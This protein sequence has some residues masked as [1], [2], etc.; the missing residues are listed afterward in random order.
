MQPAK[1]DYDYDIDQCSVS[2]KARLSAFREKR[3][4]WM[5]WLERDVHHNI[6]DQIHSIM[7]NDA[8]YRSLN[9][10]RRFA[11]AKNP[12]ASVNGML[13]EF[14]DRGYISTQVLDICKVTDKS[15]DDPKK[16]VIS[17]RR[18]LDD[19]SD[20]R[21][22]LTRENFVSYDGLPYDYAAAHQAHMDS[23]TAEELGKARWIST[24]GPDAWGT[25]ELMHSAFDKLSGIAE[26]ERTRED[27]VHEDVFKTVE[28]W[29]DA[30]I[31][32]KLRIHRNKFIGHAADE[33]SRRIEPLDR[34]GLSLDEIA[35]TQR[36]VIRIATAIGSH[37]L[38]DTA[39]GGVVPTPQFNV[40]K[41]LDMP[42][43]PAVNMND[44]G[45]WWHQHERE[46]ENWLQE[47]LNLITGQITPI[48]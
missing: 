42:L 31:L 11:S 4:E 34:L 35:E 40:F 9:E 41:N 1:K 13:G 24:K 12:T 3:S 14:L 26:N 20:H 43:I 5:D 45:E 48:A 6:W 10:A 8:A 39:L 33:I 25:S 22:L 47:R 23:L 7:W 19:I 46:R 30:P 44:I 38:P 27:L 37:I 32:R 17:L 28:S 15:I 16:S 29:F 2:D 21:R 18:L 36:T